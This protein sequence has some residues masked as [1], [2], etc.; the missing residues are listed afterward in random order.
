MRHVESVWQEAM[1][2]FHGILYRPD[3]ET[4]EYILR[5]PYPKGLDNVPN[6]IFRKAVVY[7]PNGLGWYGVHPAVQRL[8]KIFE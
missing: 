3:Y 7:Y 6:L 8:L 1:D 4:L 2:F 5:N